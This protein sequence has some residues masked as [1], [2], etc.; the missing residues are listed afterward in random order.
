[1]QTTQFLFHNV[2]NVMN[3]NY[4]LLQ[5]SHDDKSQ[6]LLNNL[7]TKLRNISPTSNS[8]RKLVS[9]KEIIKKIDQKINEKIDLMVNT[10]AKSKIVDV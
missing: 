6:D 9:E 2:K 3:K 10:Q 5:L 7:I 1:M 4:K 8:S